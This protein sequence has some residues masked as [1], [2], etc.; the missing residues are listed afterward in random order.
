MRLPKLFLVLTALTSVAGADP[1]L[2][3]PGGVPV[4]QGGRVEWNRS[5]AVNTAANAVT[6]WSDMHTGSREVHA[7]LISPNGD[8]LWGGGVQL[9]DDPYEQSCPVITATEG[10]WII[11]WIDYR[12]IPPRDPDYRDYGGEVWI[13]KLNNQGQPLWTAGGVRLDST[14]YV[15]YNS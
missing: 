11:A 2:W 15:L 14:A 7:Q 4:S 12:D 13:Q 8:L 5:V 10:G 9:T 1:R 6:T 3:D